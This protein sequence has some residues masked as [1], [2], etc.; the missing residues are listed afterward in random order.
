[1]LLIATLAYNRIS[2]SII[3][4]LSNININ[5]HLFS[6]L[7]VDFHEETSQILINFDH[8]LFV[9]GNSILVSI[10]ESQQIKQ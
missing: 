9:S 2:E 1:M 8:L 7:V 6:Y 10:Y 4:A 3:E 5:L